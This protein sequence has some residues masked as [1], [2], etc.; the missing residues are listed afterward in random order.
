MPLRTSRRLTLAVAL[1]LA[2]QLLTSL[3]AIVLLG[4]MSPAIQKILEE[5]V[6]SVQAVETMAL[7]L[8]APDGD[9]VRG[10]FFDALARAKSNVTIAAEAAP[11]A[12]LER[13]ADAALSGDPAAQRDAVLALAELGQVNREAMQ[14]ADDAAQRLGSAGAWAAVFLGIAGL[15]LSSLTIR[16]LERRV[17]APIAEI[18]RVVT[19]HRAGDTRRRCASPH[20]TPELELVMTTLNELMD[21]KER[22]VTVAPADTA[23]DREMLLALLDRAPSPGAIVNATGD[24]LVANEAALDLLAGS[25]GAAF[26]EALE[27]AGRGAEAG[28]DVEVHQLGDER[29]LV[30]ARRP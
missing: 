13:R 30:Y 18:M 9:E 5:N 6:A 24:L 26:R 28:G 7:A 27:R 21:A 2:I 1:L 15:A 3:G 16:R 23:G 4:R 10:R 11:I 22:A 17:L 29:V 20:A 8:A 14:A 12:T 25:E 19:A